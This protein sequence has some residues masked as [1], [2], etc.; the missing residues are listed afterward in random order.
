MAQAKQVTTPLFATTNQQESRN[1][2]SLMPELPT[3]S[4]DTRLRAHH[5]AIAHFLR[6]VEPTWL[7]CQMPGNTGD[8]LIWAGSE[9]LLDI[10]NIKFGRVSA[11][12]LDQEPLPKR[13]GTLV[14]PG[15]GAMT[16]LWHEWLPALVRTASCSFDRVVILPSQYEPQVEVVDKAL[17]CT[18]VYSFAREAESYGQ[19]KHFGRA[20]LA[21]DPALYAFEFCAV[22]EP[23]SDGDPGMVLVALRTDE[24]SLLRQN[25]MKPAE[26][27][28][29]ISVTMN[30]LSQFLDAVRGADSVVTDR[31]HVSVAAIMLGK[32]VRFVDPHN[33]KISRYIRYNFR[34]EFVDRFQQ[35]DEAWL[36]DRGYATRDGSIS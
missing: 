30:D 6:M 19:I 9:R 3:P 14:V 10:A 1:L 28:N 8:Q 4:L 36:V 7:L 11:R 17:A 5:A 34:R 18:N 33:N 25:G 31:L 16:L 20:S 35:R 27:N 32:T 24:G 29:D 13:S 23:R 12:E 22:D 2:N 21:P 26:C 15:S